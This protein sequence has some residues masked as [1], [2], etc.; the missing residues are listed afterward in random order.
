MSRAGLIDEPLSGQLNAS[1]KNAYLIGPG[2]A[3]SKASADFELEMLSKFC[4]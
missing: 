1:V 3:L 2:A 4:S